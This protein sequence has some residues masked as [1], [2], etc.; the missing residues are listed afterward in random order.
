VSTGGVLVQERLADFLFI[1]GAV[2]LRILSATT[3]CSPSSSSG[4]SY[5]GVRFSQVV[6]L[7]VGVV[8]R[9]DVLQSTGWSCRWRYLA[10]QWRW[11]ASEIKKKAAS[12]QLGVSLDKG[13]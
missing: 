3:C 7:G 11:R 13:R 8:V 1:V 4:G 5:A 9:H 6:T 10:E 12:G 2:V